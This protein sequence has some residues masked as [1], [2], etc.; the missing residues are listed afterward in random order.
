M[1]YI[2]FDIDNIE[3]PVVFPDLI[4]H[5][6]VVAKSSQQDSFNR[7]GIE[8]TPVSAGF[9]EIQPDY[10]MLPPGSNIYV[11][12]GESLSLKLE[13]RPEDSQILTKFFRKCEKF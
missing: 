5:S 1:K 12:R 8:G 3:L 13:S 11:A 6:D 7:W 9:F 10:I 4:Q 2:I